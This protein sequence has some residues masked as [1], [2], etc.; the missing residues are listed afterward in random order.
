VPG[1]RLALH[2]TIEMHKNNFDF[3]RLTAALLV[4]FAHQYALLGLDSP[5][6]GGMFELGSVSVATFFAISG[7]LVAQSWSFDPHVWRFAARRVLRIWPALILIT[8]LCAFVL[9]PIVSTLTAHEYFTSPRTYAYLS[10]LRMKSTFDLPG[11]FGSIPYPN[12]VNGSLWTIPIEVHWYLILLLI[13]LAGLM[14]FRWAVVAA[15]I[16]FAVYHFGI[17]HAET[18]KPHWT[19]EYGLYFCAGVSL[20]LIRDVWTDRKMLLSIALALAAAVLV[21]S[22]HQHIAMWLAWPFFVIAFGTS[23]TPVFREFGRFG[24]FSYGVYIFAFPVQQTLIWATSGNWSVA[25]YL[26]VAAA[27]SLAL[28]ALSWHLV[29]K[30]ALRLKPRRPAS[31]PQ[32]ALLTLISPLRMLI[33]R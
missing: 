5:A 14:R 4:L 23:S 8:F 9:G 33:A 22:G 30:P 10:W 31:K 15:T 26:P 7:Y 3:L 27:L 11:V 13:A 21:W 20:Y 1:G 17:Y 24:D 12:A 6:I 18:N 28:A 2:R 25:G 32:N 19:N 29:E 16:G